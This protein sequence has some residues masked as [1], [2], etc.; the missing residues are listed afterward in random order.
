MNL[1]FYK[2]KTLKKVEFFNVVTSQ[3][4]QMAAMFQLCIE[5]EYLDLSNFDT[6]KVNDFE[7]CLMNVIN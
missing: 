6:S 1:L 7:L 3:V 5:L 4:T 2:C